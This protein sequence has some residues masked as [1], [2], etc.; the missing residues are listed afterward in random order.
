MDIPLKSVSRGRIGFTRSGLFGELSSHEAGELREVADW[1]LRW[2]I[3]DRADL[4]DFRFRLA[5]Y[6]DQLAIGAELSEE[7][8]SGV[9]TTLT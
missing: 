8:Q 4:P 5:R 7:N 3:A 1:Y 2:A 6:L 9:Q